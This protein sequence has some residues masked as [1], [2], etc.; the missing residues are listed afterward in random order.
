MYVGGKAPD[1]TVGALNA[2]DL[3]RDASQERWTM[4][5]LTAPALLLVTVTMLVPILWL[6]SLSSLPTMAPSAS[7][8]IAACS[9]NR[10]TAATSS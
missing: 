10:P 7:S 4:L 1:M 5:G 3:R 2:A 6:F 9:N 8:T